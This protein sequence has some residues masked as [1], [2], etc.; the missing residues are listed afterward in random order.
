MEQFSDFHQNYAANNRSPSAQR[1]TGKQFAVAVR[2]ALD[3]MLG[4]M[5]LEE[6][7]ETDRARLEKKK[8]RMEGK[9]GSD[10]EPE[11][12]RSIGADRMRAGRRSAIADNRIMD[13][14]DE[15][16]GGDA[17]LDDETKQEIK[18]RKR[19]TNDDAVCPNF[20]NL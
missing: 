19:R 7:L 15:E 13:E 12:R 11:R 1:T 9:R 14:E 8:K 3:P 16:E 2:E 20:N 10:E 5:K 6:T 18:I 17:K 4:K